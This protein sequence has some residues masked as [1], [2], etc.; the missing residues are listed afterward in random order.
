[1]MDW[2]DECFDEILAV[3]ILEHLS[4]LEAETLLK[5]CYRWLKIGGLLTVST[6]NLVHITHMLCISNMLG[7]YELLKLLYGSS[8]VGDGDYSENYHKWCYSI[9]S[10]KNLLHVAGFPEYT[11]FLDC[12]GLRLTVKAEKKK[13]EL[14]RT[15]MLPHPI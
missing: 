3:D 15:R 1:M 14:I 2:P 7:E 4:C 9:R 13:V 8:G 10:L 12:D 11:Y 5:Q 6:P